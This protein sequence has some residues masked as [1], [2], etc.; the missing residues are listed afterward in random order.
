MC[1]TRPTFRASWTL[2]HGSYDSED[3]AREPSRLGYENRHAHARK[4]DKHHCVL[5]SVINFAVWMLL[6]HVRLGSIQSGYDPDSI[7]FG[8]NVDRSLETSHV[9]VAGHYYKI[10]TSLHQ[11]EL[12]TTFSKLSVS[13]PVYQVRLDWLPLPCFALIR[14]NQLGC[15]GSSVGRASAS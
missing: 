1:G 7:D 10:E 13:L 3:V 14:P 6:I 4:E 12:C 5:I 8:C 9:H 11:R 15:L 2:F